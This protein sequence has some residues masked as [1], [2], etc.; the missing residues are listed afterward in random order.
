[1]ELL[2]TD[3]TGTAELKDLLGFIDVNI[4]FKNI[5]GKIKTATNDIIN[6]IGQETYDLAVVEYEKESGAD[7]DFIFAVRY[8]I[9]I[10]A[11]RKFAP[12]N[13]LSHTAAGRLNRLEE[14]Q[15]SPFQWMID[16]DDDALERSYYEALDDLIKFLDLNIVSWKATDQYKLTHKL[17]LNNAFDFDSFFPI[18]NSRL[19][20]LKLAPGI[21]LCENKEIKPRIGAELFA[22]LKEDASEYESLLDKIKE[23]CAYYSLAWAMRRLSVQLFPE[24]ALQG[25][26]SDR[27]NM[28]ASKPA[29]NNEAYAVAAYFEID[30]KNAFDEIE[31]MIYEINKEPTDLVEPMTFIAEKT[32]SF[33]N[34]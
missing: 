23:A 12:H 25:Y 29:E 14:N 18:G 32:D 4:P 26:K 9:A 34:T 27:L 5:K 7:L 33:L 17:F 31:S 19:L 10:Q 21:R 15:K 24:G 13:D 20:L 8:P 28:K 1:M 3:N 22:A 6:L 16:K 30:A 11:Y 2:F